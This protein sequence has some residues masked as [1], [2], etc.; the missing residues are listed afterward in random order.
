MNFVVKGVRLKG[1]D[2]V[3]VGEDSVKNA[4]NYPMEDV[5]VYISEE[6]IIQLYKRIQEDPLG[7]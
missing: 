4:E 2:C 7:K 3:F 5:T 1:S 6:E